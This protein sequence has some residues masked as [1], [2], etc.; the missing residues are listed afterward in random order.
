MKDGEQ[1]MRTLPIRFF[2][3]LGLV[4]A[5]FV[6]LSGWNGSTGSVSAAQAT[7]AATMGTL[8][9]CPGSA[10]SAAA[11]TMMATGQVGA[12]QI[13]SEVQLASVTMQGPFNIVHRVLS[14]APGASTG[15]QR[16]TGPASVIVVDGDFV[17]CTSAGQQKFTTGGS[18]QEPAN[19]VS[20]TVNVGSTTGR[21]SVVSVEGKTP[22][23][24]A[25]AT[26]AA[27][28]GAAPTNTPA[29]PAATTPPLPTVQGTGAPTPQG[30]V[31]PE[32]KG[33]VTTVP[34]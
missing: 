9:N 32:P 34:K 20:Q 7:S 2:V 28:A 23:P 3:T 4:I 5:V 11:A 8:A 30:S 21:L 1:I 12:A 6:G 13:I 29:T 19:E 33:T 14:F 22:A 25:G 15:A 26:S 16:H 27:T 24:A 31:T 10:A 18:W 17:H